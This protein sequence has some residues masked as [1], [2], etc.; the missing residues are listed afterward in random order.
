MTTSGA[1]V[2]RDMVVTNARVRTLDPSRPAA[3]AFAVRDGRFVVVG[4]DDEVLARTERGSLRID[5]GGRTVVPGLNDSH[6]HVIRGGLTY[7]TELRWDGVPS[8][9][10]AMRLLADQAA[11]TPAPQWV[12]VVGGWVPF[13]FA[14]RRLP[15]LDELNAVAPD[16][17]VVVTCMYSR[18]LLNRAALRAAAITRDTPNPP[19]GMIERDAR[20]EPTG[21][22]LAQP[23]PTILYQVLSR[24]PRLEHADQLNSTRHYLRELNR[25]GLT[26]IIDAAGGGQRYPED[27]AVY[28]ELHRRGELTVRTA[29]SLFPQ[30]PGR[31]NDDIANWMHSV[32]RNAGDRF[33]RVNGIGEWIISAAGDFEDFMDPRP[34]IPSEALADLERAIRTIV[35]NRWPFRIHATYGETIAAFLNVFEKVDRDVPFAGLR[36]N[37]DHAETIRVTDLPRVAALGGAI[38]AQHRMGYQG[39]YFVEQYGR[40]AAVAAPPI[41]RILAE[42]IQV[43]LGTDATRVSTYN[44]WVSLHWYVTG[45][46]VGGLQVLDAQNRLDRELALRLYTRGSA[47]FSGEADVKGIIAPGML[48]DFAAL[49]EDFFSVDAD[50]IAGIESVL[51]VVDG[52]VVYAAAE[53]EKL[54]PPIPPASPSWSP[55]IYHATSF[56]MAPIERRD[57]TIACAHF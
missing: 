3:S 1:T 30:V 34:A 42:G 11:R 29:Y 39:E 38:A 46:T 51:T 27:Y 7:N 53:F 12:R 48:A 37:F 56:R 8:L 19:G 40:N 32:D 21:L 15:A 23:S 43:G 54:A 45:K 49:S 4:S 18:A 20:G 55:G 28:E 26:S 25:F 41:R 5:A 14:E 9:A 57:G 17:P 10:D 13:Q 47:A 22:L 35:A 2:S 6:I 50:A 36:W 44:P 31:E 16:T 24:A 52:K 33:L